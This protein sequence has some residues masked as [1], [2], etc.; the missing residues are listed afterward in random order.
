MTNGCRIGQPE[1]KRPIP[2]TSPTRRQARNEAARR[3]VLETI[4]KKH[5]EQARAA[6]G[7]IT[8][9]AV[10]AFQQYKLE[11]NMY[12]PRCFHEDHHIISE[13]DPLEIYVN[14]QGNLCDDLPML[15][16]TNRQIFSEVFFLFYPTAKDKSPEGSRFHVEIQSL[17]LFPF[18]RFCQT[19]GRG[20]FPV[21]I[22]PNMVDIIWWG[23]QGKANT[24]LALKKFEIVKKLV[25]LHWLQ[26]FPIWS[27]FTKVSTEDNDAGAFP[28]WLYSIRQIVALQRTLP[29]VWKELSVNFLSTSE[30]MEHGWA[31]QPDWQ[32][33]SSPE[34]IEC[35]IEKIMKAMEYRLG[36]FGYFSC[37]TRDGEQWE[38]WLDSL[39][40][41]DIQQSA[42][43]REYAVVHVFNQ[44][45]EVVDIKL[46]EELG[47]KYEAWDKLPDSVK[48]PQE[49]VL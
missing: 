29:E 18:L 33:L 34:L 4:C 39:Y 20:H 3:T 49:L 19:L 9:G 17:N 40:C 37:T 12:V 7:S 2:S 25:A 38:E 28:D 13:D 26:G 44:Y 35:V 46:R 32:Q 15:A 8:H 23:D 10:E 41:S 43:E 21:K 48:I 14:Q 6:E 30:I 5:L 24:A 36:Y 11:H 47:D 42:Y 27:C 16:L 1:P 31:P 22:A 45:R